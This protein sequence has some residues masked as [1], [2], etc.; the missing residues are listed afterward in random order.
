MGPVVMLVMLKA[1][2]RAIDMDIEVRSQARGRAMKNA[3]IIM[4]NQEN[5][6]PKTFDWKLLTNHLKTMSIT[7]IESVITFLK[8]MGTVESL[9]AYL[10]SFVK[11]F[12][13]FD[14]MEEAVGNYRDHAVDPIA[15]S[16]EL[17]E[18]EVRDWIS[19]GTENTTLDET[20][21]NKVCII[22]HPSCHG[23]VHSNNWPFP[24]DPS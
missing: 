14:S 16:V 12:K 22:Y 2:Q 15:R 23:H 18:G 5:K 6:A 24:D 9:N 7:D 17:Q 1:I 13:G 21:D 8:M 10:R 4:Q 11:G 3:L 19:E 20:E